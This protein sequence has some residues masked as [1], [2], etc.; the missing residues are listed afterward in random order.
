MAGFQV[1][2]TARA[3]RDAVE[4]L[5]YLPQR[6]PT[7]AARWYAGLLAAVQS[8]A[9][10]PQRCGLAPEADNL[11]IELRQLLFGKRR[12]VYRILFMVVGDTVHV[13][14]IRHAARESLKRGDL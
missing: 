9:A 6:S 1:R 14:P 10:L 12:G 4:A 5:E 8:L 11:G 7:A 3:E 13:L 2:L